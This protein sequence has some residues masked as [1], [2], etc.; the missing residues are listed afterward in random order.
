MKKIQKIGLVFALGMSSVGVA[1]AAVLYDNLPADPN[2]YDSGLGINGAGFYNA[3][4]FSTGIL[5]PLGCTLGNV[6]LNLGATTESTAGFELRLV[7]DAAGTPGATLFTLSNPDTFTTSGDNNL[8]K[9]IGNFTLAASTSYWIELFN[10]SLNPSQ[11]VSW[12]YMNSPA[13]NVQN[14]PHLITYKDNQLSG[15]HPI[16]D[17]PVF[18]MKVEASPI[19]GEISPVAAVPIPGAI[20][21]MGSVLIGLV[22]SWRK[23]AIL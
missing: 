20:W 10:S 9:P 6:T 11:I 12:D 7:A 8:F 5:C 13:Q 21:M 22:S 15:F 17:S 16:Q 18:L 14:Q 1:N 23:K 19:V 2:S 4:K 3:N